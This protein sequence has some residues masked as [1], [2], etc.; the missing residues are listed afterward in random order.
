MSDAVPASHV[1]AAKSYEALFVP[2][3]FAPWASRVAGA[4]RTG[5]VI[6]IDGPGGQP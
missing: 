1:D 4:G 3:L 2:A 5:I 6:R